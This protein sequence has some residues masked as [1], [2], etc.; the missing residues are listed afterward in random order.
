[1]YL[2]RSYGEKVEAHAAIDTPSALDGQIMNHSLL[3]VSLAIDIFL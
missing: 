1:M 2:D 3:I